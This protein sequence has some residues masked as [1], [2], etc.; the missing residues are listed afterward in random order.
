MRKRIWSCFAAAAAVV[1]AVVG[2]ACYA[3]SNP[4][5]AVA[6]LMARGGQLSFAFS[7]RPHGA[8]VTAPAGPAEVVEDTAE[9]SEPALVGESAAIVIPDD[10]MVPAAPMPVRSDADCPVP[11]AELFPPPGVECPTSDLPQVA[12]PRMPYCEDGLHKAR[13]AVEPLPMPEVEDDAEEQEPPAT[14][15]GGAS[16][17]LKLFDKLLKKDADGGSDAAKKLRRFQTR[18]EP[19]AGPADVDTMEYRPSDR[20]RF[21]TNASGPF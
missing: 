9:L 14:P 8:A 10:D 13:K 2:M 16:K 21:E 12:P 7:L 5:S 15:T 3:V 11:H 20:K 18:F 6:H 17:L 4:D 1:A 19:P